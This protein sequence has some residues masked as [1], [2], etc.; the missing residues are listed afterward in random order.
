LWK[1]K[2]KMS[3][4]CDWDQDYNLQLVR[5]NSWWTV[6]FNLFLFNYRDYVRDGRSCHSYG[7]LDCVLCHLLCLVACKE[8]VIWWICLDYYSWLILNTWC[9]KLWFRYD[10]DNQ[11]G[12]TTTVPPFPGY[13]TV[14]SWMHFSTS[15]RHS[16]VLLKMGEIIAWNML[17]WLELLI[18]RYCC[19]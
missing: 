13:R 2:W 6:P 18:N 3:C 12:G 14:T 8:I 4:H 7:V 1:R 10:V 17:S 5:H 9:R 19:I 16:L 11:L 15:C